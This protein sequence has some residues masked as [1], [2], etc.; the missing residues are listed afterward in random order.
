[1]KD[2]H[3]LGRNDLRGQMDSR[4]DFVTDR[5]KMYWDGIVT[6]THVLGPNCDEQTCLGT[7]FKKII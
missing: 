3:V 5:K 2:R 6:G 7:K 4:R 1:M